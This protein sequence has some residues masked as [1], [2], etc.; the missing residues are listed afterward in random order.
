MDL[1]D[2]AAVVSDVVST[3]PFVNIP[4]DIGRRILNA[5]KDNLKDG[6]SFSQ[7]NYS[8]LTKDLYE[9]VFGNVDFDFI[10]RNV[11][12]AFILKCLKKMVSFNLAQ[13][14]N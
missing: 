4:E 5:A 8:L 10:M 2:V 6:A 1:V 7:L 9:S 3:L 14:L 11:P 12:P 13:L